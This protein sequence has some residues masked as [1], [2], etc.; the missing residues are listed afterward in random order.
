MDAIK[1]VINDSINVYLKNPPQ[2]I[3]INYFNPQTES[4][5]RDVTRWAKNTTSNA[6]I[7]STDYDSNGTVDFVTI[8]SRGDGNPTHEAFITGLLEEGYS[9]RGEFGPVT[10][11][12]LEGKTIAYEFTGTESVYQADIK[13][14]KLIE[15]IG[16]QIGYSIPKMPLDD[17]FKVQE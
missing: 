8:T 9:A 14:I 2:Q 10:D 13:F 5:R 17:V 12:N 3:E 7:G 16:Y 1:R 15:G 11:P 4:E 6:S